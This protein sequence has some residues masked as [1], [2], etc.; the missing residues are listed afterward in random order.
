MCR[1]N[2][3]SSLCCNGRH[4]LVFKPYGMWYCGSLFGLG[5]GRGFLGGRRL[6]NLDTPCWPGGDPTIC[7]ECGRPGCEHEE[8]L[9]AQLNELQDTVSRLGL[10]RSTSGPALGAQT[11]PVL[12]VAAGTEGAGQPAPP[13]GF[14]QASQLAP[15]DTLKT[16]ENELHNLRETF[17]IEGWETLLPPLPESVARVARAVTRGELNALL[18]EFATTSR[19]WRTGHVGGC[20]VHATLYHRYGWSLGLCWGRP[21]LSRLGVFAAQQTPQG[22]PQS[23]AGRR[24]PHTAPLSGPLKFTN[25]GQWPWTTT[26]STSSNAGMAK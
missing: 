6:L 3:R 7:S 25:S 12:P 15:Q 10:D 8:D 19:S 2:T 16:L 17:L 11:V 20:P 23:A 4:G 26:G 1:K 24:L 18:S 14:V 13:K 9:E 22:T 21:K 5:S